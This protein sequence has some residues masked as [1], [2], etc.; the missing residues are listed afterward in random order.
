M[1]ILFLMGS[2]NLAILSVCIAFMVYLAWYDNK[3]LKDKGSEHSDQKSVIV[4]VGVLGTFVGI[5]LG[6]LGFDA[7]NIQESIPPLLNGLKFAFLT[8]IAG[9]IIS[10]AVSFIQKGK[11]AGGDDQLEVLRAINGKLDMLSDIKSL[12]EEVGKLRTELRDEQV[13]TR[14]VNLKG[15]KDTLDKMEESRALIALQVTTTDLSGFRN[16]VHEKQTESQLFFYEQFSK[17]N[18]S[19]EKAIDALSKGATEEII[20]ALETVISDF[21]QNLVE[22]FGDNFKELNSAIKELLAWQEQYKE[23][24]K[25]DQKYLETISKSIDSSKDTLEVVASKNVEVQAVY[26]Q[27]SELIRTYDTQISSVNQQLVSYVR[28]GESAAAAF[29]SLEDGFNRVQALQQETVSSLSLGFEKIQSG[30]TVQSD[31]SS[32]L[33][34]ELKGQ[35]PESLGKLEGTLVG[36]TDQFANDYQAFLENYRKLLP[37]G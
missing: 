32:A 16:E 21:N 14:K 1:N 6:L 10:I 19:L 27:L 33:S 26:D 30:I 22:Q 9:M 31:A 34:N 5:V 4:S 8:S 17:T 11:L 2:T 20:K 12:K 35:L 7:Q 18:E 13:Q 15:Y 23:M 3:T 37:N 25:N 24:L 29:G 36:L 28:V